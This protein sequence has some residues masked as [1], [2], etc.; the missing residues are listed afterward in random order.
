MLISV[1]VDGYSS[2]ALLLDALLFVYSTK[3]P[4]FCLAQCLELGSGYGVR[5]AHCYQI[6]VYPHGQNFVSPRDCRCVHNG[7]RRIQSSHT[8]GWFSGMHKNQK[9]QHDV[10]RAIPQSSAYDAAH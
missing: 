10:E 3:Q 2:R 4:V 6:W 1:G 8:T 5:E 9:Y 7:L